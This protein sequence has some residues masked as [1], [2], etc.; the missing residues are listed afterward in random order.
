MSNQALRQSE[1]DSLQYIATMTNELVQMAEA[2]RF[3][4]ISY[5]LG[6]AYAEAFDVLRG[7]RPARHAQLSGNP[8]HPKAHPKDNHAQPRTA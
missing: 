3:P 2:S 8:M 4:M 6:M 1:L 7:A 5:L